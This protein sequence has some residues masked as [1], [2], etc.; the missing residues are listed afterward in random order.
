MLLPVP[1]RFFSDANWLLP[2]QICCRADIPKSVCFKECV[3]NKTTKFPRAL[4]QEDGDMGAHTILALQKFLTQR[5]CNPGALDSGLG[6]QTVK[7]LQKFLSMQ[8]DVP[9]I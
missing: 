9:W 4:S 5:G 2:T 3:T 1:F 7:A 8:P 6:K